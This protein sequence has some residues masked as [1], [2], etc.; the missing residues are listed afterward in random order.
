MFA[1]VNFHLKIISKI[2]ILERKKHSAKNPRFFFFL[3]IEKPN[4][5]NSPKEGGYNGFNW[6]WSL[7]GA[8]RLHDSFAIDSHDLKKKKRHFA[9]RK[10]ESKE[11]NF[12][13]WALKKNI[14][15]LSSVLFYGSAS[16]LLRY[17]CTLGGWKPFPLLVLLKR[18]GSDWSA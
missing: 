13:P 8:D 14:N 18:V 16:V 12:K 11:K 4:A 2:M 1:I 15:H 3:Y 9:K 10:L 6:A 5:E 7:A 17:H